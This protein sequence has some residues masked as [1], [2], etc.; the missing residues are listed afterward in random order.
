MWNYGI[1]RWKPLMLLNYRGN[2]LYVLCRWT[3]LLTILLCLYWT[4]LSEDGLMLSE[5]TILRNANTLKLSKSLR[6]QMETQNTC[7]R[8]NDL[9]Q[10]YV[11]VHSSIIFDSTFPPDAINTR[12][13]SHKHTRMTQ[14]G[15]LNRVL[16][17]CTTP[18]CL[19]VYKNI[20]VSNYWKLFSVNVTKQL[21]LKDQNLYS[22]ISG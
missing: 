15:V 16:S 7:S 10:R 11:F 14:R 19:T 2:I 22:V 20:Q 6:I 12:D 13:G 5:T 18:H 4:Q 3:P 1:N 21:S 17:D 8:L 9:P